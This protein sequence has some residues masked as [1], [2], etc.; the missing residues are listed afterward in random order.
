MTLS[1]SLAVSHF[2]FN[3]EAI[4]QRD[5]D[6]LPGV[7][8]LRGSEI[9]YRF[10]YFESLKAISIFGTEALERLSTIII[11]LLPSYYLPLTSLCTSAEQGASLCV[12]SCL[13]A[14]PK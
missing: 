10:D 3:A 5:V 11:Y 2:G 8:V 1:S 4:H 9:N 6:Y 14:L 12:V 7:L 13:V